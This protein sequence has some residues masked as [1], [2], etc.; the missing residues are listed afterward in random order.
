MFR[1]SKLLILF[2]VLAFSLPTSSQVQP[3]AMPAAISSSTAAPRSFVFPGGI[4][5][6]VKNDEMTDQR[7]CTISTPLY[8]IHLE[9]YGRGGASVW[10]SD[11]LKL[12]YSVKPQMRL[13]SEELFELETSRHP[14]PMY[15]PSKRTAELVRALYSGA[16][17]RVRFVL[18]PSGE[19]RTIE[20]QQGDFA[21]AYDRGSQ[22]CGWPKP[23][24]PRAVLSHEPQLTSSDDLVEARFGGSSQWAVHYFPRMGGCYIA[25]PGGSILIDVERGSNAGPSS[26]DF[27]VL[28]IYRSTGELIRTIRQPERSVV[29]VRELVAVA[30]V[31]GDDG[32]LE[33]GG[34][35]HS[36][37][38][39]AD[40]AA[41]AEKTCGVRMP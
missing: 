1:F 8:G 26:Q 9:F 23:R 5:L 31:A 19:A 22:F 18:W 24:V 12:D 4:V 21:S 34:E 38:G 13:G 3:G 32:M 7:T 11:A 17:V 14:H 30:A 41:F 36:L 33:L 39:L 35:L 15:V 40:A 10:S 37:F 27:G 28:R 2:G 29:P 6:H 25:A 16:T 20:I